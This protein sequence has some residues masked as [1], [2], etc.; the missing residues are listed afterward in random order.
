MILLS[1]KNAESPERRKL[2]ARVV[3]RRDAVRDELGNFAIF[4]DIKVTPTGISGVNCNLLYGG[5]RNHVTYQSDV[6]KAY[7]QSD[8]R[9]ERPTYVELSRELT[10]L[11]FRRI[12]R[13]CVQLHKS[14]YMDIPSRVA[15]GIAGS[16]K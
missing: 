11:Q 12:A 5:L 3:F 7:V 2:K 9:T 10:P 4:Q 15:I 6:I 8:L 13:P 16:N 1:W 14:L